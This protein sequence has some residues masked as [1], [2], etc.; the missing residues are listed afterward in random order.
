VVKEVFHK[1]MFLV[2]GGYPAR[3]AMFPV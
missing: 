1:K 2:K 3:F